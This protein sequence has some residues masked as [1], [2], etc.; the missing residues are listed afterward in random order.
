MTKTEAIEL[1]KL[2]RRV[3]KQYPGKWIA[4][5]GTKLI[6]TGDTL[7][8]ALAKAQKKGVKDPVVRQVPRERHRYSF[9]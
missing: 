9:F 7:K 8:E 6:A 5:D 4:R 2:D 3:E 1:R